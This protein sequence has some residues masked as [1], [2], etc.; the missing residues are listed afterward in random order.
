MQ[1]A[2][3][4]ISTFADLEL[5]AAYDPITGHVFFSFPNNPMSEYNPVTNTWTVRGDQGPGYGRSAAAID[6]KRRKMVVIGGGSVYSYTLNLTGTLVRQTLNT[7]G[8]TEIINERPGLEY[9]PVS[10]LL[11]AWDGG[12]YVYTLNLD[13]LTW[14]KVTPAQ[15]NTVTPTA[16]ASA[17]TYG[18]WRYIPSKNV[19]IGVNSIDQNVYIYKLSTGGG[20]SPTPPSPPTNLQVR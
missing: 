17:G 11:V 19:F 18:R 16:G 4:P 1:K 13:T 8:A 6:W 20:A 9:D 5:V 3:P 15:T 7:T 12:P 10:D 14:T 2:R